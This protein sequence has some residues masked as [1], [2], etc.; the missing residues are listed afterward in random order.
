MKLKNNL[1]FIGIITIALSTFLNFSSQLTFKTEGDWESIY[2]VYVK[3]YQENLWYLILLVSLIL[4]LISKK[5]TLKTFAF[6]L[7]IFT[8]ILTWITFSS[9]NTWG[10]TP[11]TIDLE[12]SLLIEIIGIVL[13]LSS[14]TLSKIRKGKKST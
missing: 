1:F 5:G 10:A 14:S 2:T 4:Y 12:N 9:L 3:G 8:A 11:F 7:F 6:W 13:I